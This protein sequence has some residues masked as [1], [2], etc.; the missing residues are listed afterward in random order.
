MSDHYHENMSDLKLLAMGMFFA[1]LLA[2]CFCQIAR[3]TEPEIPIEFIP[4]ELENKS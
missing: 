1:G 2:Y 3:P 4:L